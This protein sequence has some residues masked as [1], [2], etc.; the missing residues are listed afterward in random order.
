MSPTSSPQVIVMG[1]KG[2]VG[3]TAVSAITTKLLLTAKKNLL[4]IDADPVISLAYA[5]GEKATKTIGELRERIIDMPEEKR[6]VTNRPIKHAIQDLLI[7]HLKG[8]NLLIMGP[9]EGPG[10]FCGLNDLLRYGIEVNSGDYDVTLVDCEAGIEQMNRRCIHNPSQLILVTDTSMR[11][12]ETANRVSEVAHKYT[13]N[14]DMVTHLIV[15]RVNG[16][17]DRDHF[18]R[19]AESFGLNIIGFLPEDANVQ[20]FNTMGIPL[21]DLPGDSPSVVAMADILSRL[22]MIE[23]GAA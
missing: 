7:R 1:G 3:K 21:L 4:V 13:V 15:N 10:C 12:F 6:K 18:Q 23:E 2:G 17:G 14:K 8:F 16:E 9:A 5:L 20:R 19:T 22:Q 11:G